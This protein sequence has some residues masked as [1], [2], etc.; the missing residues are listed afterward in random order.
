MTRPVRYLFAA[1]CI[2]V[3]MPA[4]MPAAAQIGRE[5]NWCF[6]GAKFSAALRIR[7]CTA[8]IQSGR[9]SDA[10]LATAY[11]NRGIAHAEQGQN[12]LAIAD[13]DQVLHR[14]PGSIFALN[15]R[16]AA[17]ARMGDYDRAIEDFDQAIGLNPR[18]AITFNNRGIAYAKKGRYD[19]AILDFEEALRLDPKDKS[20]QRNRQLAKQLQAAAARAGGDPDA[21]RKPLAPAKAAADA[22]TVERSESRPPVQP[23]PPKEAQ[24]PIRLESKAGPGVRTRAS[25][26][27]KTVYYTEHKPRPAARARRAQP[28]SALLR[29]FRQAQTS[30]RNAFRMAAPRRTF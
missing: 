16:G 29:F 23:K 10:N 30:I 11:Y 22:P 26:R 8:A 2:A 27:I 1:A 28:Q 3:A 19:R 4:A 17:Y 14:D 15:N 13:F 25:K 20:A 9:Q 7:G 12:D 24:N 18:Y 21:S 5:L 6:K